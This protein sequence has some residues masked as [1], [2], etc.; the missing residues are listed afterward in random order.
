MGATA[1]QLDRSFQA[2]AN[3]TRRAVVE[4]LRRGPATVTD[5]AKP[6]DMALPSFMEHLRLLELSGLVRSKKVGRVRTVHVLPNRLAQVSSWL[7]QQRAIWEQR[8]D[9]LDTYV[10]SMEDK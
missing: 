2:L 6:F 4:R 8:L 9:Q 5:L 7:D 10:S 1:V 3:A